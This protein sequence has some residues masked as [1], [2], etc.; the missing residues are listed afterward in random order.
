MVGAADA[1]KKGPK[2]DEKPIILRAAAGRP[3]MNAIP[4]EPET[5]RI[6]SIEIRPLTR[7]IHGPRGL[8]TVEPRVMEVLVALAAARGRVVTRGELVDRCWG[9]RAVSEDAINRTIQRIRWVAK[10]AAADSFSIKT[11]HKTGYRL[12]ETPRAAEPETEATAP[13]PGRMTRRLFT[14]GVLL[15]GGGA[16]AAAGGAGAIYGLPRWRAHQKVLALIAQNQDA[17]RNGT[18]DADAQGAGFLEEAVRLEPGNATAWGRLALTRTYVTEYAPPNRTASAVAGVKDAAARAL[19][20]DPR[21]ADA[22]SALAIL[23]PYY[24]DWWNAEQRMRRV[25]QAHPGHLPTRDALD[26]MLSANGRGI[27]GS[28][29]RVVMAA[30]DPLNAVYQFK[31]IFA[32]WLL[33]EVAAAD[34]AADRALQLWPKYP[35][36]WMARLWI[37]A[38][39]G[40]PE[41]AVAHIAD[42]EARPEFPP[43]MI[44]SLGASVEA[45]AS[46]RPADVTRAADL[47]LSQLAFSPSSA[48]GSVML[49]TALGE[50]DRAFAA[51]DAYLLERGPLMASVDWRPGQPSMNDQ[52][53][54][55]TNMLFVP[56]TAPMRADPRFERLVR[57]IG[58]E[59]Y[60]TQAKVAP[61]YRRAQR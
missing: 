36:A 41:R 57:D 58:L 9:G 38:F 43:W 11:V 53:R 25:L 4:L 60:W 22:M 6:G 16:L 54:R 61:D 32:H 7:E 8:V 20:L 26:F 45:L 13:A 42:T 18:P 14:P 44:Q 33:G 56:A 50:L 1:R 3:G 35:A 21:Q 40:R 52:H 24:G 49:L 28:R 23:P 29:D 55:K 30:Q 15:A 2:A 46:R 37:L 10:E 51:A 17:L 12:V 34:R 48:V 39:T 47:L 27:E 31:L 59:S 19:A 5:L